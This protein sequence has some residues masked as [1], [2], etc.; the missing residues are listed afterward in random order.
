MIQTPE[1]YQKDTQ[2]YSFMITDNPSYDSGGVYTYF[3]GDTLKIR[4]YPVTPGLRVSLRFSGN[5][6]LTEEEQNDVEA[7]LQKMNYY[8]SEW[9]EVEAHPNSKAQYGAI[10]FETQLE[11][12]TTY[13]VIQINERPWNI[14]A[15]VNVTSTYYCMINSGVSD[16]ENEPQEFQITSPD[17]SVNVVI[18][19]R[20]EEPKL[21]LTKMDKLT[22]ETL[23]G[24]VFTAKKAED[25]SDVTSFVTDENG[26]IVI[27]GGSAFESETLYYIEETTAPAHYLIP[28]TSRKAY[29]YWCNDPDPETESVILADLPEG[30]RSVPVVRVDHR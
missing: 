2:L 23:Q 8:S 5:Y 4:L 13:R 25:D 24:A 14:P 21:T 16:P 6:E 19:N 15:D 11:P 22:G 12:N 29:F 18:D 3:N 9:E 7:I 10:T 1:A 28:L 26:E 27:S 17:D 30:L 20:Y